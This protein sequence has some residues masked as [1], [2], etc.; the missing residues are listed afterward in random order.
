[1][2]AVDANT[3]VCINVE[4]DHTNFEC[5][6]PISHTQYIYIYI[7]GGYAKTVHMYLFFNYTQKKCSS[8]I[9]FLC[10][11]IYIHTHTS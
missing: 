4:P 1:M 11:S 8:L 5:P 2:H 9:T 10:I 6:E 3:L 7:Y